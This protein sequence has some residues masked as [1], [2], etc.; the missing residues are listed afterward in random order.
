MPDEDSFGQQDEAEQ[1]GTPEDVASQ[2]LMRRE[3]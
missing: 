2:L 3:S 1:S